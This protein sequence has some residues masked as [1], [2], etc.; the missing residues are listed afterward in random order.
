MDK[1]RQNQNELQSFDMELEFLTVGGGEPCFWIPKELSRGEVFPLSY[2][3][4]DKTVNNEAY[5]L[6]LPPE[7]QVEFQNQYRGKERAIELNFH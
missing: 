7:L 2:Q 6:G 3:E 4:I 5:A 1:L